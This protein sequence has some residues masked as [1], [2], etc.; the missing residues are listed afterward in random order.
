M[1]GWSACVAGD[2][3]D[4]A[5]KGDLLAAGNG[6]KNVRVCDEVPRREAEM[7]REC[8]E[9]ARIADIVLCALWVG[10]ELG[11]WES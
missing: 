8:L 11:W 10:D 7:V 2:A 4:E 9:A 1:D 5:A 3:D 6:E